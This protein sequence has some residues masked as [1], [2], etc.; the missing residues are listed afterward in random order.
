MLL[1]ILFGIAVVAHL[2][3]LVISSVRE[4]RAH[5][6][7]IAEHMAMGMDKE[8]AEL[9]WFFE[10]C[11]FIMRFSPPQGPSEST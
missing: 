2:S 6:R 1:Y 7:F 5:R 3:Y 8:T 9:K 10:T 11:P 4:R